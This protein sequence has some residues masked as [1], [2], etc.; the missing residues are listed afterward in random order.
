MGRG[1]ACDKVQGMFTRGAAGR[2]DAGA[3]TGTHRHRFAPVPSKATGGIEPFCDLARHNHALETQAPETGAKWGCWRL[4]PA[5]FWP[6]LRCYN[7]LA[8]DDRALRERQ[9]EGWLKLLVEGTRIL[10]C[11]IGWP[12]QG[13]ARPVAQSA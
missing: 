12:A 3:T 4:R 5:R 11:P 8:E 7:G 6:A 9:T 2:R 10:G 1:T 13:R